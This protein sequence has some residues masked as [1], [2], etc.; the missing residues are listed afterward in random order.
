MELIVISETKLKVMLDACDLEKYP[1][2]ISGEGV[3]SMKAFREILA[4]AREKTGFDAC[5]ERVFVQAYPSRS[6]GCELFVTKLGAF[7][8]YDAGGTEDDEV[9][10]RIKSAGHSDAGDNECAIYFTTIDSLL[11]F[12]RRISGKVGNRCNAYACDDSTYLIIVPDKFSKLAGEYGG[13]VRS[14]EFAAYTIDEHAKLITTDA[15]SVLG[16]LV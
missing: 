16:A 5:S 2:C 14:Y 1:L 6:G 7:A 8:S 13:K 9:R 4:A 15:A 10:Y 11:K 12:C 3:V